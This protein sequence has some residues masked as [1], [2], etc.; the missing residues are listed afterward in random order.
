MSLCITFEYC[1]HKFLYRNCTEKQDV[2]V[3]KKPVSCLQSKNIYGSLSVNVSLNRN[4]N[5]ENFQ[6]LLWRVLKRRVLC[7]YNSTIVVQI[8]CNRNEDLNTWDNILSC[9]FEKIYN[10]LKNYKKRKWLQWNTIIYRYLSIPMLCY[11]HIQCV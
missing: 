10:C 9:T 6:I 8:Y 3:L 5:S 4:F 2:A 1:I 11:I 7:R